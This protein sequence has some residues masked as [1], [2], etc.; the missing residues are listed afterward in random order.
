MLQA[1]DTLRLLAETD[2][3]QRHVLRVR[4]RSLVAELVESIYLKPEKHFGRVYCLIQVNYLAGLVR[5]F[6]FGPGWNTTRSTKTEGE[7][8][9]CLAYGID[10]RDKKKCQKPVLRKL[11]EM[12]AKP[13]TAPIFSTIPTTVEA[14]ADLFLAV[15]KSEMAKA[16]FRVVPAKV[17]RFVEFVG[18]DTRCSALGLQH[19]RLFIRWLRAEVKERKMKK[20]T[21]RVT[22]NRVREYL[23]WLAERGQITVFDMTGSAAKAIP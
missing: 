16:S 14:A 19:W 7:A 11:A 9:C 8:P 13:A 17:H 6:G 3:E 5:Q 4:L 15:R 10:L 21:A 20:T 18:N 12:L 23:R 22:V 1:Q 2:D